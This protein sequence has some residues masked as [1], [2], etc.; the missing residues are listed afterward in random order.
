MTRRILLGAA[1][2]FALAACVPHA[3]PTPPEPMG[4]LPGLVTSAE[5]EWIPFQVA[6]GTQLP[7]DP[8]ESRLSDPR[9]LGLVGD[10]RR[11]AWSPDGRALLIETLRA[12]S[13][14]ESEPCES[15]WLV[16][17]GHGSMRRI[18]GN[19]TRARAG[20]FVG[21]G[22]AI[23]A[24]APCAEPPATATWAIVDLDLSTN[25]RRT[26]ARPSGEVFAVTSDE[27]FAYFGTRG[28][29]AK[30][31]KIERIA[32]AG[33]T[34]VVVVS[35]ACNRIGMAAVAG[36]ARML[37]GCQA[38]GGSMQLISASDEGGDAMPWS[39]GRQ[40]D[41]DAALSPDG[42]VVA[43]ASTRAAARK[44]ERS[45]D[46]P[47]QIYVAPFAHPELSHEAPERLTFAGENN[48]APALGPNGRI[49]YLSDRGA[50]GGPLDVV[51]A[52]FDA[53]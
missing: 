19:G 34:P 42:R 27:S 20:A 10:T 2:T 18:S 7:E 50:P 29:A 46:G 52:R 43:F 48:R 36:N 16:P 37:Y 24:E 21:A 53:P 49:A 4:Q 44:N 40:L 5:P 47:F 28:A 25:E 51:V 17:L 1:S 45:A 33:G 38:P 12:G 22:R 11:I 32:I 9:A 23:F 26:L 3:E 39:S 35:D 31:D 13:G 30:K 15:V 14:G 41:A 8:R 6:A